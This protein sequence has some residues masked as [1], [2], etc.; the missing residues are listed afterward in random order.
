VAERRPMET[1]LAEFAEEASGILNWLLEGLIDYLDHGLQVPPE[2]AAAT[3]SYRNEMDAVGEFMSAH[4][5]PEPGKKVTARNLYEAF[6]AWCHLNS[7]K[8]YAE[9]TFAGI[10]MQKGVKKES[11]RIRT[12]L[13]ISLKDPPIDPDKPTQTNFHDPDR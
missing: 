2:V 5:V 1:I 3:D 4:V 6:V 11:G 9:K 12:Y 8:P 10:M 7:I 13:D